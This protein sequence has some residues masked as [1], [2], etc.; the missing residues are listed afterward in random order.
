MKN[1][2]ITPLP[3]KWDGEDLWHVGAGYSDPDDPHAYVGI[4]IDPK[5]RGSEKL[6]ENME[7]VL[8]ACNAHGELVKACQEALEW[9]A[10][11]QYPSAKN[12]CEC[13]RVAL[14]KASQP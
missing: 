5:L 2:D 8:R 10:D 11:E 7:F 13:L 14:K 6:K 12:V 4:Q 1:Q 3:W 9:M